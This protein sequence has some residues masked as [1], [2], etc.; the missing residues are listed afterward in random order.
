MRQVVD[1]AGREG[2]AVAGR[3]QPAGIG[4]RGHLQGRL[5][6]VQEGVEHLRVE[7]AAGDLLGAEAVM[8]PDRVGRGG[9]VG[10]QVLGALA[11]AD[12]LQADRARPVD[13]LGDQRRLV[14]RG[15]GVD[16][17]GLGGAAGQQRA[18]EHVGLDVDHHDVLAVLAGPKGV[19]DAGGR[20]AGGVDHD[21]H[22]RAGDQRV[23]V[24]GDAGRAGRA[25]PPPGSRAAKRASSQPTRR[26]ACARPVRRQVGHGDQ[27]DAGRA[28]RLRQVH[29]AEL[30]GADQADADGAALVG[31]TLQLGEQGHGALPG[32]FAVGRTSPRVPAAFVGSCRFGIIMRFRT[33]PCGAPAHAATLAHAATKGRCRQVAQPSRR[34][35][36]RA[37]ARGAIGGTPGSSPDP[38]PGHGCR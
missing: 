31:A 23:G 35:G 29:R 30:A 10:R 21:V 7:V 22:E 3:R 25:R 28:R 8:P 18:G 11:G 17:T 20:A 24:V 5:G 36:S 32:R 33:C 14:A 26:S 4:H 38:G 19:A 37:P 34:R 6:A 27:V 2:Q 12:H 9:V 16:H 13:Q 1:A 15:H